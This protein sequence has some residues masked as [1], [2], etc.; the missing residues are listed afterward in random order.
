[1][2]GFHNLSSLT[3]HCSLLISSFKSDNTGMVGSDFRYNSKIPTLPIA[4]H[5]SSNYATTLEQGT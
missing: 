4:R 3:A 2:K 5:D 1:M